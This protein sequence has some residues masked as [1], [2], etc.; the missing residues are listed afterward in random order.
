MAKEN[1]P[2]MLGRA[3]FLKQRVASSG[4]LTPQQQRILAKISR[5]TGTTFPE[6]QILARLK[7]ERAKSR[8]IPTRHQVIYTRWRRVKRKRIL[9]RLRQE[10]TRQRAIHARWR[11]VR[12][13]L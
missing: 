9:R 11:R 13:T 10:S 2:S 1:E 3:W 5:V 4:W 6:A 12:K 8:A 7:L